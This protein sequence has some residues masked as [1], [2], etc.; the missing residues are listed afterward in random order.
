MET[1]QN[2]PK[3][4]YSGQNPLDSCPKNRR[5]PLVIDEIPFPIP[6]FPIG[7]LRTH[8]PSSDRKSQIPRPVS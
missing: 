3:G 2:L 1:T 5:V 7:A 8:L 4:G 6:A